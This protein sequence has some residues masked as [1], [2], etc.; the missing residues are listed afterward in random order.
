MS[1]NGQSGLVPEQR[2]AVSPAAQ[3]AKRRTNNAVRNGLIS[4]AFG[5]FPKNRREMIQRAIQPAGAG[6]AR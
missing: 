4:S 3:K 1:D 5:A 2:R 6:G